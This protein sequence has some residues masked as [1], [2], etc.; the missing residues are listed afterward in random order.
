M[1][2]GVCGQHHLGAALEY[3]GAHLIRVA[4]DQLRAI[5][6]VAQDI[7][8]G[9]H[10][11]Q[12]RL[13]LLDE[14][15]ERLEVILGTHSVGHHDDMAAVDVDIDIR[16]ADAVDHHRALAADELDGVAGEGLQMG[17]EA[18]LGIVHQ[19]GDLLIGAL[20]TVG[21]SPLTGVDA[22]LVQSHL[23]AVLDLL[24]DLRTG[25]VDQGDVI[26]H[27]YLGTEVGVTPGDRRRGIDHTHDTGLDERIS[28]HPV[29]VENV[30]DG[31]IAGTDAAE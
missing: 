13:I 24:E 26:G 30:E 27:Q 31:D 14:R 8:T 21:Q 12:H 4:D 17:D 5:T 23:G 7:C 20:H 6:V 22:G 11:H 15:L 3:V 28:G 1:A 18:G 29:E 16:D 10:T 2:V 19:V 9:T 25:I